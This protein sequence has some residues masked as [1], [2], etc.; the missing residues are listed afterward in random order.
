M[1]DQAATSRAAAAAPPPDPQVEPSSQGWSPPRKSR[2]AA[3]A[4]GALALAGIVA[5]LYAWRLPPFDGWAEDTDNAY[6]RGKV[7]I[8]SPQVSG[9][10]TGVPVQDFQTVKKGDVLVTIDQRIYGARVEQAKA[11]L[12]AQRA[13]LANSQQ[14]QRG[15]EAALTGQ[16]AGIANA[17]AQLVRAQADMKRA[18]ALVADGS[19]SERERDQTRAALLAA[20]AAVRQASAAQQIG[21]QDVRSV[22][23]GRGGLEASVAAAQAAL[24]LAQV[25]LDNTVIR[26]PVD[27]ELSEI[28]VRNGAFVSAGTQ[29]MFLVPRDRWVI[30]NYKEA[31]TRKMRIGQPATFRID[32][33]GGAKLRGHVEN[34]SPAAGSEFAVL[35]SD[36][37]TG[38]FVKVAQRIAVRVKID[39]GQEMAKRLRPG[40]SVELH[41]ETND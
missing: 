38:N 23:V 16:S 31:Q 30:A 36:N 39:P 19:I 35:K 14:S 27:G 8:I 37:A 12:A 4:I 22:I 3:V 2:T 10:V 17:Q 13:A 20:Q 28:G 40:M 33:L 7:T 11:N 1:T 29:L 15:R 21:Q 26:A 41:V 34:L 25:D 24:H 6:V 18:A 5:I 9:Y 32:A